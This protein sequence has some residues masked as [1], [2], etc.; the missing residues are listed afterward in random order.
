MQSSLVNDG[1]I[2][3]I[4]PFSQN[5]IEELKVIAK[6]AIKLEKNSRKMTK[7]HT[8]RVFQAFCVEL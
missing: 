3:N 8:R 4:F 2:Q 5:E 6:E 7:S 1:Y